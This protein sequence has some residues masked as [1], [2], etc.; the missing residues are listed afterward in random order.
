M[1]RVHLRAVALT[2]SV[3]LSS[4]VLRS[5]ASIGREEEEQSRDVLSADLL[6]LQTMDSLRASQV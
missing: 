1:A 3:P 2:V 6:V 4:S 5:D